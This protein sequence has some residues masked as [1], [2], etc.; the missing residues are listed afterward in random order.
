MKTN[1]TNLFWT[2]YADLMTALFIVM[3]AL[4]ILSYK[5]FQDRQGELE[6]MASQYQKIQEIEAALG[7]LEGEYFRFD[8]LNKRHELN[9][10]I[11]FKSGK[12]DI[13]PVYY[14]KLQEAGKTLTNTIKNIRTDQQ[15]KYIV[16]IEGMAARYTN[17]KDLWKNQSESERDFTYRLSYERALALYKFWESNGVTFDRNIFEVIIAGSGFFGAGRYI[18]SSEAKNKRF[19]IQ[20]I[21]KTGTLDKGKP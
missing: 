16:V 7:A 13:S 2:S 8:S 17:A 3:L 18:G 9:I 1:S 4:F 12:S 10:D 5:L 11:A 15:V 19:L 21:P 14:D 6:V 20:V